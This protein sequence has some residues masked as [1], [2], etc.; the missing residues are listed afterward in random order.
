MLRKMFRKK[1]SEKFY[2]NVQTKLKKKWRI[3]Y[4]GASLDRGAVALYFRGGS[5]GQEELVQ[6]KIILLVKKH[7]LF[8]VLMQFLVHWKTFWICPNLP[9]Q[10]F[11]IALDGSP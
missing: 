6:K 4:S 9:T 7:K 5:P 10:I 1:N 2:Q 11:Q 8:C 3:F